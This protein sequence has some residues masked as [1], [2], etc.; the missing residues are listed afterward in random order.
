MKNNGL[1][2][3]VRITPIKNDN[4]QWDLNF[5]F[6]RNRNEVTATTGGPI[7]IAN[8]TGAPPQV[9]EGEP[10]G[11]FYGTYFA[12]NADGSLLLTP[13]G[14]PQQERGDVN[15]DTPQRDANGKITIFV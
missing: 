14:L 7:S 11:V 4:L 5:N 15:T 9:R 1:E 13:D 8:V 2:T 12:R 6:T 10:L 3:Y